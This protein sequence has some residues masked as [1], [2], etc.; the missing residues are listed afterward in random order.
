MPFLLA[1]LSG[2]SVF[3]PNKRRNHR[4]ELVMVVE[5]L[6]YI[7]RSISDN[8]ALNW[9]TP[10]EAYFEIK[11]SIAHFR[12]F[13]CPV[14][15]HKDKLTRDYPVAFTS[16][17]QRGIHLG[18]AVDAKLGVYLVFNLETKAFC[19]TQ[20]LYF[21]EEYQLVTK[22]PT[23]WIFQNSLLNAKYDTIL[24]RQTE[25]PLLPNSVD[26]RVGSTGL[27]STTPIFASDER[28]D[29][30]GVSILSS[31]NDDDD[32]SITPVPGAQEPPVLEQQPPAI[33]QHPTDPE[34]SED[35]EITTRRSTRQ[36]TPI[37]RIDLSA[38]PGTLR[39]D[40][41]NRG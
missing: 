14:F 18:S 21:D 35:E 22:S 4:E 40:R 20:S 11:P 38:K 36:K 39:C 12:R 27:T 2:R 13:G 7:N 33:L 32:V 23:G 9:Q 8:L 26:F 25:V 5:Q 24:F 6:W 15:L 31:T 41:N 28:N 3:G 1:S 16:R 19:K 34:S 37:K 29:D 30:P 17:V 10:T